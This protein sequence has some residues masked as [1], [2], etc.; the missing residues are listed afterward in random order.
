MIAVIAQHRGDDARR[1]VGRR[2]DDAPARG[3]L[4]VDRHRIDGDVVHDFMRGARVAPWS[5]VRRS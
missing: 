1:A 2:G 5:R 4:L 3:V